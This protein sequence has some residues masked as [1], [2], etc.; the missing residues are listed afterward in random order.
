MKEKEDPYKTPFLMSE[1]KVVSP[2]EGNSREEP[3]PRRPPLYILKST[4]SLSCN[5]ILGTH[6]CGHPLTA[7]S[8]R[9][10]LRLYTLHEQ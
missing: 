1:V 4:E 5:R 7:V 2:A 8:T 3:S 6:E 10:K 9:T